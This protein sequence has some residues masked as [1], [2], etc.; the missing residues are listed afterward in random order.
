MLLLTHLR[1][2]YLLIF[3][4]GMGQLKVVAGGL[5]VIGKFNTFSTAVRRPRLVRCILPSF[6]KKK[7]ITGQTL[8][9]DILRASTIKSRY[10]QAISLGNFEPTKDFE[11]N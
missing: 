10:G 11:L 2:E 4:E 5:Q 6:S 3:Q 9:L 8:V 1:D 7:K